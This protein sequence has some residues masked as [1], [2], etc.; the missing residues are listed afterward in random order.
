MSIAGLPASGAQQVEHGMG[1]V[2]GQGEQ[3]V[4]LDQGAG[5]DERVS[6]DAPI[7]LQRCS[8]LTG[9]R[10]RGDLRA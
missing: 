6:R 4:Y 5:V 2:T 3:V 1:R 10:R 9:L 8:P 7:V